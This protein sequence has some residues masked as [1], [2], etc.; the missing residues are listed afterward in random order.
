MFSS[1]SNLPPSY[2]LTSLDD[3]SSNYLPLVINRAKK[4]KRRH[5][6][7][8]DNDDQLLTSYKWRMF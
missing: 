7:I 6:D 8:S 2:Q 5:N 4:I 1:S 3:D